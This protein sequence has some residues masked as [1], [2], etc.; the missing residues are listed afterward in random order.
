[1]SHISKG[2]LHAY[3]DGALDEYPSNEAEAIRQHL[4]ACI[5]CAARLDVERGIR[6]DASAILAGTAPLIEMP[7]LEELRAM[8]AA[9]DAPRKSGPSR[10]YRMGWAAS[11]VLAV[12]GGWMLRDGQ[13]QPLGIVDPIER[14][15]LRLPSAEGTSADV[16]NAP[17]ELIAAMTGEEDEA[18]ARP[19]QS[20]A[21]PSQVAAA[22]VALPAARVDGGREV[23][24]AAP[25]PASIMAE[26]LPRPA[27]PIVVDLDVTD[28]QRRS[29]LS[30][31]DAVF[32][33]VFADMPASEQQTAEEVTA[34]LDLVDDPLAAA[35]IAEDPEEADAAGDP[36]DRRERNATVLTSA[37]QV[38][39]AN[40]QPPRLGSDV[41]RTRERENEELRSLVILG[42][43]VISLTTLGEG[44][45]S[46][47]TLVLQYLEDGEVLELVH[48]PE[49]AE[50]AGASDLELDGRNELVVPRDGGW[51]I[52][53][54]RRSEAELRVLLDRLNGTG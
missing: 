28:E 14:A 27:A 7:P 31:V 8:A 9:L 30:E 11:I 25:V 42:L 10:L 23:T 19:V 39:G 40:R 47:G 43:E 1:M 29:V 54:A 3:L 20:A 16:A 32:R 45:V 21:A 15:V 18:T 41:D 37:R 22:E 5:E 12:G 36:A 49:G 4:D 53:Q 48:L 34:A 51:L 24:T 26:A 2:A 44:V 38:G 50:P 52:L 46:G 33:D 6:D 17:A 13:V 35:E